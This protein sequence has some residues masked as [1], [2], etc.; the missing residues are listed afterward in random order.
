MQQNESIEAFTD[1]FQRIRCAAK[2]Q[3]DIRTAALFK[4]AL[5]IVL[6]KKVSRSLLNLSL[7]KQD[8]VCKVFAK[9][10]TVISSNI[11]NDEA[12]AAGITKRNIINQ[13][14]ASPISFMSGA[15]KSMH[16]PK[17]ASGPNKQGQ[18]QFKPRSKCLVHVNGNHTTEQCKVLKRIATANTATTATTAIKTIPPTSSTKKNVTN[19][20]P[21]YHGPY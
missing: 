2:W 9:A 5:P 11:C 10:R 8:S 15:E 1:R 14:S 16:N 7:N 3:D 17:N 21:I 19:V 20:L 6:Y 18:S 4:H 13:S 12:M